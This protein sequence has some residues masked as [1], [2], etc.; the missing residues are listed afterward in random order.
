MGDIG[1]VREHYEV[2][3]VEPLR[4]PAP[5]PFPNRTPPSASSR[6][7]A[8]VRRVRA[9]RRRG[10]RAAHVPRGRVRPAAAAVLGPGLVRRPEHRDLRAAD[11]REPRDPTIP[12]AARGVRVRLLRLRHGRGGR[13]QPQHALRPGRRVVLGRRRRGHAG[14]PGGARPGRRDV[15]RAVRP[16]LAAQAG[17]AHVPVGAGVRRPRR[18]ARRAPAVRA[19]LLRGATRPAAWCRASLLG[20]AGRGGARLGALPRRRSS[21]RCTRRGSALLV[22]FGGADRRAAVLARHARATSPRRSSLAGVFAWLLAPAFGWPAGCC[23]CRCCA[24]CAVAGAGSCWR[25]GRG[26]S[27]WCGRSGAKAFCG[28][29]P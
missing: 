5:D 19:A 25:C 12:V 8:A 22:V 28:V 14:R 4:V 3:P 29:R 17:R 15:A 21:A 16:G 13:A 9:A 20:R 11:R 1:E 23:A 7:S 27:R 24:A 6:G 2:L 26:T 10:R 18:D